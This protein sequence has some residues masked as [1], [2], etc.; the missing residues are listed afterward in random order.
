[1]AAI[2]HPYTSKLL[3]LMELAQNSAARFMTYNYNHAASVMSVKIVLEL[4]S[5]AFHHKI[6]RLSLFHKIY[7]YIPPIQHDLLS[8]PLFIPAHLGHNNK[9]SI[10]T[11]RN[12]SLSCSVIPQSLK[13]WNHLPRSLASIQG[14]FSFCQSSTNI[15]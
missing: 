11:C 2:W 9:I 10:A 6:F 4:P 1:M 7:Y 14:I 15:V 3:N 12:R 13:D 8:P 5:T